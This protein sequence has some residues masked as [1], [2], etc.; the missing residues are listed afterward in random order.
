MAEFMGRSRAHCSRAPRSCSAARVPADA[1]RDDEAPRRGVP[2]RASAVPGVADAVDAVGP[3]AI[4]TCVASSGD[5]EKMAFTL[6]MTGL[7]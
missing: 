6:G 2:G 4:A 1:E 5:H 7:L 3:R